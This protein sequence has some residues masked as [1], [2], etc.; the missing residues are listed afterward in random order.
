MNTGTTG[1]AGEKYSSAFAMV[2]LKADEWNKSKRC[3]VGRPHRC[4]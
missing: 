2:W 4:C 3:S 1:S